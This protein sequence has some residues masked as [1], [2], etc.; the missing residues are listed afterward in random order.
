[1]RDNCIN[2]IKNVCRITRYN[3]L[4][5]RIRIRLYP[6][7]SGGLPVA[8][9]VGYVVFGPCGDGILTAI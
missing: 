2:L 9:P 4:S 3:A 7:A 1:M 8:G 5:S 6:Q